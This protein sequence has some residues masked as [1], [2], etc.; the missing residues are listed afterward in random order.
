MK[1]LFISRRLPH[2]GVTGG[3]VIVH[4]RVRRLAARGHEVSLAAF[5]DEADRPHAEELRPLLR[6]MELVKPPPPQRAP[7]RLMHFVGASTPSY[8]FNYRSRELMRKVGDLAE[9]LRPD[10]V[11]AEFSAMGQYL[12]R[13]PYLP[14]VRKII[15][16]HYSVAASYRRV[17]ELMKYTARGVRSRLSLWR[18]LDDY[19]I[20][21]YRGVDRVL[22]LTAQER[23]GL[24][25]QSSS[26]RISVIPPG[27]DTEFFRPDDQVPRQDSIL[28]TGHFEVDANRDAVRWFV[29][30]SW[31]RIRKRHPHLKFHIV[32]PGSTDEF[33][34][35]ARRDPS[36]VVVGEVD[37]LRPYLRR[38]KVFVCP[39]RLGSG[40]RL[41]VLEALAAGVPVVS[42]TLGVEGI[43]LH[44]GDTGFIA[45]RTAMMAEYVDLLLTDEDLRLR[46]GQQGREL[47]AERFGWERCIDLL[48]DV[49]ADTLRQR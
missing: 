10:V 24:L 48:E 28:F 27:V 3:H 17:A 39:I 26:L 8:Y 11:I 6:E 9:R 37:D 38:A 44:P 34:A 35:L 14:A 1:I 22:V 42:T 41:K 43:P 12:Y 7:A 29:G 5:C 36:V 31:P 21:M 25:G 33:R 16:C 49:I 2:A 32:G 20:D 23:Y 47:V 40:L 45:D 4:Q 15:S 46:M 19:E 13:N 30:S 18:G